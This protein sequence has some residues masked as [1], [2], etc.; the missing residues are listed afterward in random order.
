M[1]IIESFNILRCLSDDF[2]DKIEKD[3]KILQKNNKK[4]YRLDYLDYFDYNFL[5]EVK[6][7]T[8]DEIAYMV[9]HAIDKFNSKY[10]EKE[11]PLA[12][13]DLK[14]EDNYIVIINNN[15]Y[16]KSNNEFDKDCFKPT[17][18]H[19]NELDEKKV[20][21]IFRADKAINEL[22]ANKYLLSKSFNISDLIKNLENEE[23][24]FLIISAILYINNY[25]PNLRAS[26]T[27]SKEDN[28]VC[29]NIVNLTHNRNY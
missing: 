14:V 7:Y 4:E 25:S 23:K 17:L 9:F 22:Y 10:C 18:L 19:I 28:A 24:Y 20:T 13:I 12:N 26:V 15:N 6:R 1:K 2:C 21:V 3:A 16:K 27:D 8:K 5:A 29:I 11:D